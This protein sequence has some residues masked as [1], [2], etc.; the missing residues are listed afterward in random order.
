MPDIFRVSVR[1]LW[2][3][4]ILAFAASAAGARPAQ[5]QPAPDQIVHTVQPGENLFRIGLQW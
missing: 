1:G 2:V 5:A 3:A 4:L